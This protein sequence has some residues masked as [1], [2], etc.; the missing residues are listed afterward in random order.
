GYAEIELSKSG[1]ITAGTCEACDIAGTHWVRH[2]CEHY[3]YAACLVEQRVHRRSGG[4]Q[5][6][7]R[8]ECN[9]LRRTLTEAP[10]VSSSP[11]DFYR[12]V[13]SI[14][15]PQVRQ[16][17]HKRDQACLPLPVI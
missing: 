10:G 6:Y 16:H 1:H 4:S 13:A 7:V 15:P 3:R 9:Q 14:L 2:L 17:L 5:D 12:H 8:R 11:A